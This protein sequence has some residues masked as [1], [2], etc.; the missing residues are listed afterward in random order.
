MFVLT[1]AASSLE[2]DLPVGPSSGTRWQ[3]LPRGPVCTA[4][5][6]RRRLPGNP[7]SALEGRA[8]E[9]PQ[10]PV[11]VRGGPQKRPI[12]LSVKLS[13]RAYAMIGKDFGIVR[14]RR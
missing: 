14:I 13:A 3:L 6:R 1:V 12:K 4:R 10:R 2:A 7:V 5:G 11:A 9:L 8:S